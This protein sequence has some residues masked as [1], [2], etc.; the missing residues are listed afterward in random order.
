MVNSWLHAFIAHA[1]NG[2]GRAVHA[3]AAEMRCCEPRRPSARA[4]HTRGPGIGERVVLRELAGISGRASVNIVVHVA[5][6]DT[7][8]LA[9]LIPSRHVLLGRPRLLRGGARHEQRRREQRGGGE[10]DRGSDAARA[11][12]KQREGWI[13]STAW[14]IQAASG[15][16]DGAVQRRGGAPQQLNAQLATARS[17]Q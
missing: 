4:A 17:T 11:G 15:G 12:D 3:E 5:E 16:S 1:S 8:V 2:L 6:P 14:A 10:R 9:V 13:G 7:R